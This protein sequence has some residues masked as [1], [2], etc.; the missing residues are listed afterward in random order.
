MPLCGAL[1]DIAAGQR[2][3]VWEKALSKLAFEDLE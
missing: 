2:D 1:E 3:L